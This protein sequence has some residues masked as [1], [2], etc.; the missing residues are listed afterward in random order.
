MLKARQQACHSVKCHK[1]IWSHVKTHSVPDVEL[2]WICISTDCSI[3]LLQ[4]NTKTYRGDSKVLIG[5]GILRSY[6]HM[7]IAELSCISGEGDPV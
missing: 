6:E 5:V 7:G 2:H 3:S 4:A 1:G